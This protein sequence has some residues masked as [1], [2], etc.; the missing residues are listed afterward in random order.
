MFE[1]F[2]KLLKVIETTDNEIEATICIPDYATTINA[3]AKSPGLSTA[4]LFIANRVMVHGI[5]N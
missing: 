4:G 3:T 5:E 1:A 2:D